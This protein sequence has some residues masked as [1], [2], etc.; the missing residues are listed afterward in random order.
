MANFFIHFLPSLRRPS[1]LS[2]SLTRYKSLSN[3][4]SKAKAAVG[5]QTLAA[6]MANIKFGLLT[7][8]V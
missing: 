5:E 4:G 1:V 7:S 6:L 3:I 8:G 2:R